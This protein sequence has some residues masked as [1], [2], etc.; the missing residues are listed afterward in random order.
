MHFPSLSQL[1]QALVRRPA[2]KACR[3]RTTRAAWSPLTALESRLLLSG[4][5][6]LDYFQTTEHV[7]LSIGHNLAANTWS[8]S[9]RDADDGISRSTDNA[10][11]YVGAAAAATRP[12]SSSFSFLG[13]GAGETFYQ[14]TAAQNP[15]LLYLGLASYGVTAGQVDSYTVTTESKQR[16]TGSARWIKMSLVNVEHFTP[17]GTA[18]TGKFS[19]WLNTGPTVLMASHNDGVNNPNANGLDATDGISADDALWVAAGGHNHVNYG[20]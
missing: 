14:L 15:D 20:F 3:R 8:L 11:L 12:A 6:V 17:D 4:T 18:G 19:A 1:V 13:V 16:V 2:P 10:L 7:D 5:P 9:V